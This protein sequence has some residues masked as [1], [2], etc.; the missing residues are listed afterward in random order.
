M[1]EVAE[2]FC[3]DSQQMLREIQEN[4]SRLDGK[5]LENGAHALKGAV[6]NFGAKVAFDVALRLELMGENGDM[7]QAQE[8]FTELEGEIS[9]LT[10]ELA[11]LRKEISATPQRNEN[12]TEPLALY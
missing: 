7:N 8:S 11:I 5:A 10:R 6:G 12:G 2:L 9:R 1:N 3:D 4:I